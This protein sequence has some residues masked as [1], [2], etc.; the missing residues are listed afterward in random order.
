MKDL[1]DQLRW[2]CEAH[3]LRSRTPRVIPIVEQ[4][5]RWAQEHGRV[6]VEPGRRDRTRVLDARGGAGLP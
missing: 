1:A 5:I 4:I 3:G 2:L 6:L